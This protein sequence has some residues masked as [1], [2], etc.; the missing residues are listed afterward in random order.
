MKFLNLAVASIVDANTGNGINRHYI[1]QFGSNYSAHE[2][3][4]HEIRSRS[5]LDVVAKIRASV[6]HYIEE[7]KTEAKRRRAIKD[8]S[9]M[10][11]RLL[12]DI[13]LSR[14]DLYDIEQGSTSLE[15]LNARRNRSANRRKLNQVSGKVSTRVRNIKSANQ[16]QYE[17]RKCA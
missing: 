3:Q 14:N 17:T 2:R 4:G 12:K 13:G 9:G 11:E 10:N 5:F 6:Q 8:L 15:A 1:D 7:S 16:E